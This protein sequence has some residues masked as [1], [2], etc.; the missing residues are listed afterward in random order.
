MEKLQQVS[1]RQRKP[2]AVQRAMRR[3]TDAIGASFRV[4]IRV[5]CEQL[6]SV[7]GTA[8]LDSSTR[9]AATRDRLDE[10]GVCLKVSG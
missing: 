4:V 2:V 3:G 10:R 6:L 9:N 5:D 7:G 8:I 1:R